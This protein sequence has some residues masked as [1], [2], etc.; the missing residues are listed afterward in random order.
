M[1]IGEVC[2][3]EVVFA[4]RETSLRE[5][6][7]L[8]RRYHVGDLVIADSRDGQRFPVGIVTDRDI[9]VEVIAKDVN[10]DNFTVGDLMSRGLVTAW[11]D[12]G[13]YD[14][15][16]LMRANSVRRVPI[17]DGLGALVG[18]VSMDDLIELL[19]EEITELARIAPREREVEA[20]ARP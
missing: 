2:T 17:V 8:M 18:L 5:A 10:V 6:A 19:A 3:R 4:E 1:P 9:V 13:V 15:I 20:S 7:K 12:D 14:T 11:E 16:R